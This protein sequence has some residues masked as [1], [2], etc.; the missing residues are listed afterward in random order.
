M[1]LKLELNLIDGVEFILGADS[2]LV[3]KFTATITFK[4]ETAG[5]SIETSGGVHKIQGSWRMTYQL[6]AGYLL[7]L[8]IVSP[9]L[10]SDVIINA[11]LNGDKANMIFKLEVTTGGQRHVVKGSYSLADQAIEF[12]LNVEI[13]YLKIAKATLVSAMNFSD[14]V[15]IHLTGTLDDK[16]NT[17]DLVYEKGSSNFQVEITSPFIPT[18][19][20][21]G[22]GQIHGEMMKDMEIKLQLQNNEQS[23][24]G[25]VDVQI[26]SK[27]D[28][29]TKVIINTPFAGYKKM[30]FG[31]QYLKEEEIKVLL[32]L[33]NQSSSALSFTLKTMKMKSRCIWKL[34]HQLKTSKRLKENLRFLL[35]YLVQRY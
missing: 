16:V 25:I 29:R 12:S 7:A 28:I 23:V 8:E 30:K 11:L 14:T 10:P 4:A 22:E 9:L 34:K 33:T 2:P 3:S 32:F 26:L 35:K 21:R 15:K 17:F 1:G 13:P 31:A 5:F 27:D 6:P 18:G 20:V 19:M 24:S